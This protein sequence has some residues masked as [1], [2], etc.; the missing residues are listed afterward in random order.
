[1]KTDMEQKFQKVFL[2]ILDGFGLAS[3]GPGNAISQAGMPY[4]NRLIAEYPSFSLAASSLTVGMPWGQSGNSE[5]GHSAIGTGRIIIQDLA[6]I[7]SAIQTG[8]FFTNDVFLRAAAHCKK[9]TSTLHLVGCVSPG[10]IHSHENHLFA[11]M[12]FATRQGLV[13]AVHVITDGQ[14]MPPQSA[15]ASLRK[16]QDIMTTAPAILATISGRT[17]AMDR[18]LN[19][20]LT[21]Q[22][23]KAMVD[24]DAPLV[25]DAQAYLEESYR[26]G[27]FDHDIAPAVVA[28]DGAPAAVIRDNDAVIFFNFRNDRMK[29]LAA[30]FADPSFVGFARKRV[31]RN[32]FVVTMTR[33]ADTISAEIAYD[34]PAIANT[35]GEVVSRGGAAQYRIAEKEKEAHVTNFFNGG[36]LAPFE[37]EQ[38]IIVSSRMLKGKEYLEHPEMSARKVVDAVREHMADDVKLYV[39]NFAN[40]DMIGHTGNTVATVTALGVLDEYLAAVVEELISEPTNAVVITADHGNAEE[41]IDPLTGN[42]DTMHSTRNVPAVFVARPFHGQGTGKNLS[43]LADENPAGT[44]V[45]IAPSVLSLLGLSKP[46]EMT[47]SALL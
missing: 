36:R 9:H 28:R 29:Q 14:D 10:G 37:R 44:L 31:P 39:V 22:V 18:V 32:L 20:P 27:I 34:A 24:G 8:T 43:V 6:S 30:P 46:I 47:G 42:E 25:R 7:N 35:L 19:W 23:W 12:Q 26:Q 2:I 5:V 3:P 21:E 38:R 15:V 41:L 11:L 40:A 1:M 16:L 33:Y 4:L 45:D 13:P 17:Y